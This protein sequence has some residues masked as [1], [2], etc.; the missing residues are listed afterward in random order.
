M[1]AP[2]HCSLD[3][4]AARLG[5]VVVR[6]SRVALDL[7]LMRLPADALNRIRLDSVIMGID[8]TIRECQILAVGSLL[9]GE[10]GAGQR[11]GPHQAT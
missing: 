3:S 1:T 10:D 8:K 11:P 7:H 5:V 4:L 9:T 6:L 2:N